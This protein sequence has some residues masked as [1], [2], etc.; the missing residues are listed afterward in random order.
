LDEFA[1]HESK[2]VQHTLYDISKRLLNQVNEIKK[3]DV[4]MPNIHCLLVDLSKF[5]QDNNNEIF[6]PIDDPHGL[7]QCT[8]KRPDNLSKDNSVRSKL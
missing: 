5:G 8:L 3:I 2:S 1:K 7:I 4:T 6:V